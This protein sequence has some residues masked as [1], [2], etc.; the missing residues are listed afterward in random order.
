M[1]IP[2]R[3][4][5]ALTV[6]LLVGSCVSTDSST[7][8]GDAVSP[9]DVF[10]QPAVVP[11][12]ADASALPINRIR[13]VTARW[14]DEV[15]LDDT[16]F[17]VDPTATEWELAI[18]VELTESPVT[19]RVTL[20]LIHDDGAGTQSIEYSGRTDTLTVAGG[21][22]TEPADIPLV[23]GPLA[24]LFVTG[25]AITSSL[26]VVEG[27]TLALTAD[28]TTT[29]ST[30]P[31]VFWTSLDT[32][33]ATVSGS[34][35]LG[36]APGPVD[37][38][39]TAGAVSDTATVTV[40]VPPVDSVLVS[41][42]SA[43]VVEGSAIAYT[44]TLF[45]S[46]GA[47]L[48]GRAVTWGTADG[49]VATVDGEGVVTG[50]SAGATTVTATSEGISDDAI[51][52]VSAA[53]A[54]VLNRWTGGGDGSSWSDP[55]NWSKTAVPAAG[56][57][58]VI[59]LDGTYTVTMDVDPP[60]LGVLLIGGVSG[61]Q[62]L[63]ATG[64]TIGVTGAVEVGGTGTLTL[65][66]S[67]L[68]A[69]GV[70]NAAPGGILLGGST[71]NAPVVNETTL[72]V[73][74]PS[75]INGALQT[76]PGSVL[77]M[78]GGGSTA[79]VLTV[80][81]GFTNTATI[82]LAGGSNAAALNVTTGT[83]VNA[84][85]ATIS[86]SN[87]N[88]SSINADLDN[89]GTITHTAGALFLNTPTLSNSGTITTTNTVSVGGTS[90]TNEV[91]GIVDG[92]ASLDVSGVAFTNN[93]T[94]NPGTS[95]GILTIEG[96]PSLGATSTMNLELA[97]D[98]PGVGHDQLGINGQVT[99]S[100]GLV[101][102]DTASFTPTL[103]DRFAVMTFLS[104]AGTFASVSLPTLVDAVLDTV[105]AEAGEV[106]T[107]YIEALSTPT[108]MLFT[109]AETGT[110][111]IWVRTADGNGV[112][113]L[114]SNPDAANWD[115]E[116]SPDGTQIVFSTFR[117]FQ[118]DHVW[119]MNADGSFPTELTSDAVQNVYPSWSPTG[120]Q[121]VFAKGT[122]SSRDIWIMNKDGTGQ[123]QLT[124]S[125][126]EDSQPDW[127]PDGRQIAFFSARQG[128][129][130]IFTLSLEDPF[131]TQVNISNSGANDF[132]PQWSPDGSRIAFVSDR[133]GNSEIYVMDADGSN[134][135][136][137][138]LDE[139]AIDLQP[140]WSPDGRHIVF[141]SDRSGDQQIY[142]MDADGSNQRLLQS[143]TVTDQFPDLRGSR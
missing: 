53:V 52:T 142:I 137:L 4:P 73:P 76:G 122:G 65:A 107:L 6:L 55:G 121:I 112:T 54:S 11:S 120:E 38:V 26:T 85:G 50:L 44:V 3:P 10:V 19:A 8:V 37:I 89:Q 72:L 48:S 141:S 69:G 7:G 43:A 128:P 71:I 123:L 106:D 16:T 100:G 143:G 134:Q 25:V 5:L 31:T 63:S 32:T 91:G 13:A 9:A 97:G 80:A 39:A 92:D 109:S 101:V 95:P 60:S 83:L 125:D 56:D 2:V 79:G 58:V 24:N 15:V 81:S 114:T 113:Q 119:I 131:G 99:L 21:T 93:G 136:R 82:E 115:A 67:V 132:F 86:A 105:W 23:R 30:T 84:V 104:R 110:N 22:T 117:D 41:P 68:D 47:P 59:D 61:T 33:V 20:H 36:V 70:T 96:A 40:I 62:T 78:E 138:T 116:W 108:P 77:R 127:S 111:E 18:G 126:F 98:L 45:D 46:T 14:P 64:R 133:D 94:I 42:D 118:N 17:V 28:V 90:F 27:Q 51:V 140:S 66:S 35:A 57:S 49:G 135:I 1:R 88:N 87:T 34:T 129:W 102:L 124:G 75:S 130:Q 103:G 74:S 12:A 139:V 29:S